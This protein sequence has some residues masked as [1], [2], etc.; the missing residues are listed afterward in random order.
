MLKRYR[1]FNFIPMA[2]ASKAVGLAV[3]TSGD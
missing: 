2:M 3:V 1:S